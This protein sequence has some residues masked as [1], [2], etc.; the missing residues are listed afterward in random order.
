MSVLTMPQLTAVFTEE[1]CWALGKKK[2]KKKTKKNSFDSKTELFNKLPET[3]KVG[4]G[5]CL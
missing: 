4:P 1:R 2:E 3:V 5:K